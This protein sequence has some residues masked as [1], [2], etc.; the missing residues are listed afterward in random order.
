MIDTP[1]LFGREG[2]F[3]GITVPLPSGGLVVGREAPGE[4]RLVFPDDSDISRHHCSIG[5]DA[6]QHAFIV[7]DLGST[8]GTFLLPGERRLPAHEPIVCVPDQSIRLGK[9]AVFEF[10]LPAPS[11]YASSAGAPNGPRPRS[12]PRRAPSMPSDDPGTLPQLREGQ[13][14]DAAAARVHWEQFYLFFV[15]LPSLLVALGWVGL[16]VFDIGAA[17]YVLAGAAA[18]VLL[19]WITWMML[20]GNLLGNSIRVGD[21]QYPQLHELV[22]RA[23][24]LLRITPPTVLILQG[25]GVFELYVARHFSRRGLLLITS[26]MLDDLT[27]RGSSR[28]LMFFIGRQL[29]LIATGYFD[30]WFVKHVLGSTMWL[31][32]LAWTRR[33]HLTADRLGLLVCGD[34]QAAEQA[35]LIITAGTAMAANTNIQAVREQRAEVFSSFWAWIALGVSSYPLMVDRII[36]L[37]EFA[38]EAAQRRI[39]SNAPLELGALPLQHRQIRTLPLIILHGHDLTARLE[40]V[41][42]LQSKLPH[43]KPVLM[44]EGTDGAA[45][46]PEK[47][48][49]LACN[50]RGAVALLT[51]D[52][53]ALARNAPQSAAARARQNV[54]LEIGWAWARLGRHR[55]LLLVRG[56]IEVPSDLSGVDLHRFS[57]SPLECAE[58]V[59]D[60]VASLDVR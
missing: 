39:A 55:L 18:F 21:R 40:M 43:V 7:T 5:Y 44:I 2:R 4:G 46:L 50:A 11:F 17:L 15:C 24:E 10:Q 1:A 14:L 32:H 25:H 56:P 59:R 35:L 31:L 51:P 16:A 3:K 20:M 8:N 49:R 53:L 38:A 6:D 58:V 28:E 57:S 19:S 26:N 29:G 36:R 37:R 47:F 48:E 41:N 45:S 30:F 60:F 22:V 27:E 52:D 54:I 33:C 42:F 13:C 23:S 34:A 9:V 12:E